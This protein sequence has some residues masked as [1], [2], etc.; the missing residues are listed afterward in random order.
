LAG[1]TYINCDCHARALRDWQSALR[2][3]TSGVTNVTLNNFQCHNV[4][5][6]ALQDVTNQELP[7]C[8]SE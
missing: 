8:S 2:S 3:S 7:T 4:Q 1:N 6:K 5:G